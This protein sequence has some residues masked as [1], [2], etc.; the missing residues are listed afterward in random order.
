VEVLFVTKVKLRKDPKRLVFVESVVGGALLV[1]AEQLDRAGVPDLAI[2]A[3]VL[4]TPDEASDL[5][6]SLIEA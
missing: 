5:A 2:L 4:L 1:V 3:E 6:Q